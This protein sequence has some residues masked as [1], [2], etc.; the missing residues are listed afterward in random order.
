MALNFAGEPV[1]M[2]RLEVH[3][4]LD[5]ELLLIS[6]AKSRVWLTLR[7]SERYLPVITAALESQNVPAD[8]KFLPMTLTNLD[9]LFLAAGRRGMWRMT[10]HEATEAGLIVNNRIDE[11]L[12]PVASSQ[13][14]AAKIAA[15]KNA[16]G[17][18]T[19]ALAAF[20]DQR[21]LLTAL[22]QADGEKD[23][24]R[25]YVEES[26]EKFFNQVLAGKVLYSNPHVYGY[27]LTKGWSILSTKR[28]RLEASADIKSL[29]AQYKVDYKTFR[30]MNP[31][32]LTTVA[33]V[34]ANLNIP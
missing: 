24:Y 17:S 33:P 9:P 7:R 16:L 31:H 27:T 34:G 1:A 28:I 2:S 19:L 4:G 20:I 10:A 22:T 21:A 15:L 29:A 11:R 18:W 8:F 30:A 32:L 3:E 6:E 5:Q 23:Y 26:A 12:D 14:A 13:A 25:L